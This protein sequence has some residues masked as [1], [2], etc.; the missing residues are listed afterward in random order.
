MP[1][2]RNQRGAE[3]TI[4]R[5]FAALVGIV[6]LAGA[7]LLAAPGAAT[8]EQAKPAATSLTKTEL[9]ALIEQARK[10]GVQIIVV[11]PK[12]AT[13]AT[14][15][16]SAVDAAR[17]AVAQLRVEFRKLLAEAPGAPGRIWAGLRKVSPDGTVGHFGVVVLIVI[18]LMIVAAIAER[19]YGA[20]LKSKLRAIWPAGTPHMSSKMSFLLARFFGRLI[21]FALFGLITIGVAAAVLEEHKSTEATV[22]ILVFAVVI[23][24]AVIEFWRV[25]ISPNLAMYRLPP[26]TD[27][28]AQHLFRWLAAG[29]IVT[30][31][32]VPF[33]LW[34]D[35]LVADRRA[36]I[37]AQLVLFFFTLVFNLV[38][39][40]A[41][42][43]IVATL[44][45]GT[46]A[47]VGRRHRMRGFLGA[48]WH[49]LLGLYLVV[50]WFAT[51]ARIL[52]E[53]PQAL[54]P[55]MGMLWILLATLTIYSLGVVL[56][57]W[58]FYRRKGAPHRKDHE[59]AAAVEAQASG[60][61]EP[62]AG[63]AI[64]PGV[65]SQGVISQGV[66]SEGAIS[67]DKGEPPRGWFSGV[68]SFEDLAKQSLYLLL[69]ILVVSGLMLVWG[70]DVANKDSLFVRLWDVIFVLFMGYIALQ[71]ARIWIQRKIDAE[72]GFDEPEPG[73][74]GAAGGV[75]RLATL[76]P[77]FRNFILATIVV[78]AVMIGL[79]ELGIDIAPL[80][81]G[82][83]VI[84][85][86]I[87]FG[88]QTLIRDIFSGAFFLVDDAFRKGEYIDIGDVKG[89][90]ERISVRS[91][92]VRHHN[93]P[94][95]TVPFGE[96][97]Y[98]TNFS[99][100]WVMMKLK[101]RVTYDTDVDKVRKLI[102]QLGQEL[103][104]YPEIGDKFLMPLKSQGVLA[105]E[106]SAMIL[107]V[108]F[109]T[110]PGDQFVTR[111]A[112]YAA[113]QELFAKEGIKFA[114]REVTVRVADEGAP[115]RRSPTRRRKQAIEGAAAAMDDDP[116]SATGDDR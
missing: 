42:R 63:D 19:F 73:E 113:I 32:I 68:R 99:R 21:G 114:H 55:T 17:L 69:F 13:K 8:A 66:I 34:L 43:Q 15:K 45:S 46:N 3:M 74:E 112:V 35:L 9:E 86:A 50:A 96:I 87:G 91:M 26:L 48:N 89:T 62:Q 85:L 83:G 60:N 10:K 67:E 2:V 88:A 111:K 1:D 25:W 58:I 18:G 54:A 107:R 41:I 77:L 105:M 23:V 49:V 47:S 106:D 16:T 39:L 97:K 82:A 14:P 53:R 64:S 70:V 103:L 95:H 72:G 78:I 28:D 102:K 110:K 100:D 98:L 80:F 40:S 36:V 81:A 93:G 109:M 90:V 20:W 7:T 115:R 79:S 116:T 94:L 5:V 52:L 44:I 101:L 59:T 24:R 4:H 51:S 29:A 57:D 11:A 108:K 31:T 22:L 61:D 71:S 37:V 30:G 27:A 75:S 12:G 6:L 56:L 33:I 104:E 92:Q 65:I 76:L 84:G 38:A